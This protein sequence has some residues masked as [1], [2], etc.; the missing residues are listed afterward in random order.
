MRAMFVALACVLFASLTGQAAGKDDNPLPLEK[1]QLKAIEEAW[2]VKVKAIKWLPSSNDMR[3]LVEWQNDAGLTEEFLRQFD[4]D[5]KTRKN[6]Y[7]FFLIDNDNVVFN[8]LTLHRVEGELTGK[9]GDAFYLFIRF[10]GADIPR[11]ARIE[12]RKLK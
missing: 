6:Y 5:E 9:S 2:L 11:V 3:L 8:K 7:A 12:A 1:W 10:T 4:S